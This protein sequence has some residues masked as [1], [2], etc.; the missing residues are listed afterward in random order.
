MLQRC[1]SQETHQEPSTCLHA[2]GEKNTYL[3]IVCLHAQE[4]G[5]GSQAGETTLK[6]RL[7]PKFLSFC[8]EVVQCPDCLLKLLPVNLQEKQVRLSA[9]H[10]RTH[11]YPCTS[12]STHGSSALCSEP[13]PETHRVTDLQFFVRHL[14]CAHAESEFKHNVD[15]NPFRAT[16]LSKHAIKL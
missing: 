15:T 6:V 1:K 9:A 8:I 3:F 11:Q 16:H 4:D 13:Q 7:A 12:T 10:F 5:V 14:S 2:E